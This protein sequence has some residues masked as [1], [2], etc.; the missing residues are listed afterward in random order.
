MTSHER[1]CGICHPTRFSF[2]SIHG[3]KALNQRILPSFSPPITHQRKSSGLQ[4]KKKLALLLRPITV[5]EKCVSQI[6]KQ[7]KQQ[8]NNQRFFKKTSYPPQKKNIVTQLIMGPK[9]S[10]AQEK[11]SKNSW[12]HQASNHNLPNDEHPTTA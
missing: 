9:T 4:K 11:T 5:V 10:W 12:K 7:H 3:W 1:I 2:F 8:S 6:T